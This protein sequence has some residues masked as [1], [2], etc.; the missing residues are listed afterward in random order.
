MAPAAYHRQSEPGI[1]SARFVLL[2][3]RL[4]TWAMLPLLLAITL[5]LFLVARLILGQPASAAMLA[6]VVLVLFVCL[7]FVFPRY[8]RRTR[9]E[10]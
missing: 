8:A 7:W 2:A 4:L 3:S 5:D 9:I 1:I 10:P 6:G